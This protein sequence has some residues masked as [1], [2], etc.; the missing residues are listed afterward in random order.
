MTPFVQ[1]KLF[2]CCSWLICVCFLACSASPKPQVQASQLNAN[3]KIVD[4]YRY[5]VKKGDS[6]AR[7][8]RAQIGTA[9]RWKDPGR[10]KDIAKANPNLKMHRIRPGDIV[11]IPAALVK[12]RTADLQ[13]VYVNRVSVSKKSNSVLAQANNNTRNDLR[14]AAMNIKQNKGKKSALTTKKKL[15]AS[16]DLPAYKLIEPADQDQEFTDQE[17][18][19]ERVPQFYSCLGNSCA[20][21]NVQ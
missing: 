16:P 17:L 9:G 2:L 4:H 11:R 8:A 18:V 1:N 14:R 12:V 10:W 3:T 20:F 21:Y 7:I 5:K 6:L 13:P 19:A 15:V